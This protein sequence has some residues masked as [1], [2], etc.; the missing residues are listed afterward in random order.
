MMW[1]KKYGNIDR[2]DIEY[3]IK[4][5]F[6]DYKVYPE[7]Q[8]IGEGWKVLDRKELPEM[9]I[10]D[11]LVSLKDNDMEN[12]ICNTEK[13]LRREVSFYCLKDIYTRLKR[14]ERRMGNTE[15]LEIE[16]IEK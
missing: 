6:K 11:Y 12:L 16:G 14:L 8:I 10:E 7:E 15:P 4:K 5:V 2:I 9:S 3:N 13:W 1:H